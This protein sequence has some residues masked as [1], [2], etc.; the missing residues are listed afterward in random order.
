MKSFEKR[1]SNGTALASDVF[2]NVIE[3]GLQIRSRQFRNFLAVLRFGAPTHHCGAFWLVALF[4]WLVL[5][6]WGDEHFEMLKQNF[7]A[8]AVIFH[9]SGI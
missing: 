5:Q 4:P 9:F 3:S 2:R 8:R 1:A 7:R 6:L